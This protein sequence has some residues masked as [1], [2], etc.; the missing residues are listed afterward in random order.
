MSEKLKWQLNE[1]WFMCSSIIM[2][3]A[4]SWGAWELIE[5]LISHH[6]ELK[7]FLS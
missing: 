7:N 1:L 5:Y 6:R 3:I 2:M 4:L